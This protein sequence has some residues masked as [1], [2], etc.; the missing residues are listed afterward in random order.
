MKCMRGLFCYICLMLYL[1]CR[2]QAPRLAF[3]HLT[4]EQGLPSNNVV[5]ILQDRDGYLWAATTEGLAR[6]DGYGFITYKFDPRDPHSL[7]QNLTL[8]LFEDPDG[9]LWVGNVE[10]GVNKFDRNTEKFVDYR[11]PQPAGRFE[12]ALRSVSAMN[13]DRQGYFWIGS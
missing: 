5:S 10:G 3:E 12:T 2:A 6:Y 4:M 7:S 9:D 13:V 11:P 8:S 1:P